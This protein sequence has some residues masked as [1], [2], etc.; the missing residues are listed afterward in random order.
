MQKE[1]LK[2]SDKGYRSLFAAIVSRALSDLGNEFSYGATKFLKSDYC[3]D[4]C[5]VLDIP[6]S[7]LVSKA[8]SKRRKK[9]NV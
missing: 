3:K 8:R 7:A 2:E 6:Y 5:D 1:E 4:I 9:I